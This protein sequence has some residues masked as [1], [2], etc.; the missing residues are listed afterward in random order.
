M[1]PVSF[2]GNAVAAIAYKFGRCAPA[3]TIAATT[4]GTREECHAG[5]L[6]RPTVI[7]LSYAEH[8]IEASYH[9]G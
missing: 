2:S 5:F 4:Y 9:Y 7:H 6:P 8:A 3:G 1:Y